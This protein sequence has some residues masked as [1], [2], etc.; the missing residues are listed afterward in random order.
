MK[1]SP[2]RSLSRVCRLSLF[3]AV[4]LATPVANAVADDAQDSQTSAAIQKGKA[5]AAAHC[6]ACHAIGKDDAPPVRTNQDTSFR[7][8]HRRFPIAMLQDA[9]EI[10][11]IEGHDEMPAFDFSRK[12]MT[13]LL[14]YID[15]FAPS[16][17][18]RYLSK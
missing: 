11:T 5:I 15:S 18:K 8:L 9:L 12:E 3:L 16:A 10:G 7:D 4:A 17:E 14:S 2:N 1:L 13:A 6:A